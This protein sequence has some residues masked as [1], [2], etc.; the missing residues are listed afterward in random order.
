MKIKWFECKWCSWQGW[1]HNNEGTDDM[2]WGGC[3]VDA[4]SSHQGGPH[5]WNYI[6]TW[7][8]DE[9]PDDDNYIGE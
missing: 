2:A 7:N 5:Q 6:D 1:T 4:D 3:G 8:C 9:E